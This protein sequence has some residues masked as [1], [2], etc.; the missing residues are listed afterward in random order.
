MGIYSQRDISSSF[1]GDIEISAHG[2]IKLA[3]S[4]E[5]HK[6]VINFLVRSDF[7]DYRPDARIGCNLGSFIG[8]QN[9]KSN[10]ISMEH[11]CKANL[12]KFAIAS[13]DLELHA[14]PISI[15]EAGVFIGTKGTYLDDDG[16]VL[17]VATE[18]LTYIFPFKGGNPKPV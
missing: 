2:D 3:D 11:T 5:T 1:E 16:N 12:I 17:D 7:G 4:F 9:T 6:S 18:I 13:A 10:I 8:K 15:D 14:L